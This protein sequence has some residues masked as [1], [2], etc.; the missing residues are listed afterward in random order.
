MFQISV[1]E[2]RI[3]FIEYFLRDRFRV[4]GLHDCTRELLLGFER[5]CTSWRRLPKKQCI[6][7][8][9]QLV[10]DAHQL[11][12][13]FRGGF[14]DR[15]KITEALAHFLGAIQTLKNRKEKNDLLRQVLVLLE[16][17]PYQNVEK[18]IG[19]P[20]FDISFHHDRV[21]ALHDRILNFVRMDG[22]VV[23]DSVPEIFALQHLLQ[24]YAAVEA[25]NV[26]ERHRSKPVAVA[27]RF[28]PCR[29]KNL[30]CLLTVGG[31]VCQDFLVCQ[32]RSR[33]RAPAR[34]ADHSREVTDN[35]NRLV[36]QI[37]EMP[38]FSQNDRVAQM[39]VRGGGIDSQLYAQRPPER[40]FF[41]QLFFA[42]DLRGALL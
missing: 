3:P 8:C 1:A 38:Q 34:I 24:R 9:H 39:N 4:V 32:L 27:N 19:S 17:A 22:L 6:I 35:E 7:A 23:V 21:P 42:D 20:Q 15:D 18:L 10:R 37:L 25:N 28:R 2:T 31:G 16:I 33:G 41:A 40:E 26:F 5:M 30:E 29:V 13:H 14:V 12:E 36:A 11:T